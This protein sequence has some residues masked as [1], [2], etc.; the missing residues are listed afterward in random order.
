MITSDHDE[1][2]LCSGFRSAVGLEHDNNSSQWALGQV[3]C[4]L[5]PIALLPQMEEKPPPRQAPQNN[6]FAIWQNNLRR[7]F[8]FLPLSANSDPSFHFISFLLQ[9]S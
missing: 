8:F 6:R 4:G 9:L 5:W 3:V 7:P 1:E 2:Y